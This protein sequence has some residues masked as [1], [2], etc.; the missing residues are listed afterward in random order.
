VE[1]RGLVVVLVLGA[2]GAEAA[3]LVVLG[4]VQVDLRRQKIKRT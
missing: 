3:Q 2:L 1:Q 4:E